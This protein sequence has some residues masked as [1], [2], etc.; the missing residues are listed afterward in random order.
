MNEQS[1]AA[2]MNG[3]GPSACSLHCWFFNRFTQ[4][5]ECW[6][7]GAICAEVEAENNAMSDEER[8]IAA[9]KI[10]GFVFDYFR[11]PI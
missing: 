11:P 2:R 6:K 4:R 10:E 9:E 5:D 1:E 3:T 7:C 8:F